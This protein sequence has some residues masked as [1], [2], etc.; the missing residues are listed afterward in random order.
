MTPRV[1]VQN[2]LLWGRPAQEEELPELRSLS[3][4]YWAHWTRNNV[5]YRNFR[6]YGAVNVQNDRT[7]LLVTRA[8]RN[9]GKFAP[10]VWPGTTFE[11]G[12]EEFLA[13]IGKRRVLSFT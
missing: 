12:T 2:P 1:A 9:K 8:M 3:D 6:I 10:E 7:V 11:Q 5:N 13:L 4:I